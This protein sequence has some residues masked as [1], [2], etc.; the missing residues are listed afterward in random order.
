MSD[1][2]DIEIY[3]SLTD[4][5]FEFDE[6]VYISLTEIADDCGNSPLSYLR[7]A[8]RKRR[9]IFARLRGSGA[10]I[11][12]KKLG[13]YH[14]ISLK[15]QLWN[16]PYDNLK[17]MMFEKPPWEI[18][19]L[20][21]PDVIYGKTDVQFRFRPEPF[22]ENDL[23]LNKKETINEYKTID[24]VETDDGRKENTLND[25]DHLVLRTMMRE[26]KSFQV[27]KYGLKKHLNK[28]ES[29]KNIDISNSAGEMKKGF[30]FESIQ[31]PEYKRMYSTLQK[32][33]TYYK[34]I[35]RNYSYRV[36]AE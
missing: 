14:K 2:A 15:V 5:D 34:K 29:I 4:L 33:C 8:I 31:L 7:K 20:Y 16:L 23:F 11:T 9:S 19:S 3:A 22:D 36:R 18:T 12:G 27:V 30:M 6:L 32:K 13:D 24:E 26:G 25:F 17:K 21:R 35:L 1:E 10:I 28:N